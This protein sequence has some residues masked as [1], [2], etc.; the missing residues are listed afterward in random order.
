MILVQRCKD[1]VKRTISKYF[2]YFIAFLLGV[3]ACGI[4]Q[5]L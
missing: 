4:G 1:F 2:W 5:A 3:L